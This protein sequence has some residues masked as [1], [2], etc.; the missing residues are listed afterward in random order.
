MQFVLVV[1]SAG[2]ALDSAN[3][4]GCQLSAQG[5]SEKEYGYCEMNNCRKVVLP[6]GKLELIYVSCK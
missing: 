5:S 2:D 4:V 3:T 1:L 6:L